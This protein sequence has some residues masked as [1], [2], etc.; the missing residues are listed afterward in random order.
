MMLNRQRIY[1]LFPVLF[2]ILFP[3]HGAQS[4]TL[5]YEGS[6]NGD[7]QVK[8]QTMFNLRKPIKD[9]NYRFSIP[10][11][12]SNKTVSQDIGELRIL[13]DP[14]PETVKDERDKNGNHFKVAT[15]KNPGRNVNVGVSYK[16]LVKVTLNP[17]ENTAPFPLKNLPEDV[18][19][20]LQPFKLVQSDH[21]EI[22][23]LSRRLTANVKT[24]YDAVT[25]IINYAADSIK[26][27]HNPQNYDALYT[28]QTHS[29]NCTNIAHLS[30]ALLR[31]AGIPSRMVGGI[32]LKERWEVP[33]PQGNLV[34]AIGQGSHA[35]IEIYFPDLGWL[36]YDPQQSKQFTSTRHVKRTHGSDLNAIG[37]SWWASPEL[38]EY[39]GTIEEKFLKDSVS[40]VFKSKEAAPKSYM[41][42]N[43]V[44]SKPAIAIEKPPEPELKIPPLPEPK[45]KPE[46]STEEV[47]E[48]GNMEFPTLIDTYRIVGNRATQVYNTETAEYV[49]S[50]YRYAQAFQVGEQL[51]LEQVSLAMRKFGGDGTTYIDIVKDENG[52]PGL[53]GIRSNPVFIET[54]R[55]RPGYYWVNFTFPKE[56][57]VMM[58]K[59]KY[60]I[61]LRHSGDVVM[62]WWYT[63]GKPYGDSYDTRSTLKGYQWEDI[64]NYDFVFKIKARRPMS[65]A[66][67]N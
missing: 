28:L 66:R 46:R 31:A 5:I 11:S 52:K 20:Y 41:L 32:G 57:S 14:Q 10:Q 63:P 18:L 45:K 8:Q 48:F 37:D 19:P 1:I 4:E 24:E 44:F 2:L 6:L 40:V 39:S 64:L 17:L 53:S 38:P 51:V 33:I 26:Y 29:G 23:S 7:I 60:W 30:L 15:W 61:V 47:L 62:N 43:A 12:F 22:I 3:L 9:L 21:T 34:Q 54:I 27:T 58:E 67:L 13:Y 49:T 25:A 50:K 35:W 36:S 55:K 56:A 59:G 16:A 65:H 42:S